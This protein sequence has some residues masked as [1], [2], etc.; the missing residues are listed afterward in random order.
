MISYLCRN[1]HGRCSMK[2]AVLNNFAIFTG[3]H[4][5]W[6]LFLIKLHQTSVLFRNS[7]PEVLCK[8][9]GVL[10]KKLFIKISRNSQ[11]NTCVG[12]S[13][14]IMFNFIKKGTPTQMLSW[15][16]CKIFKSTFFIE[17]LRRQLLFILWNN[18]TVISNSYQQYPEIYL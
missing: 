18:F 4:L 16:F 3:K 17:H 14:L 9:G 5:C 7:R 10:Q 13:S 8:T 12:V 11:E 15:E 6:S 2:K 1:C